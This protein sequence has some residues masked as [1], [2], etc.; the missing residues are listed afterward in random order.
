MNMFNVRFFKIIIKTKPKYNRTFYVNYT[1][2]NYLVT[3]L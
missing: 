2:N 1:Q 3:V